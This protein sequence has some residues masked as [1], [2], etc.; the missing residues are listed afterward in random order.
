MYSLWS[1]ACI[2]ADGWPHIQSNVYRPPHNDKKM[3]CKCNDKNDKNVMIY[4]K[5]RRRRRINEHVNVHF[6]HSQVGCLTVNVSRFSHSSEKYL[7]YAV[8]NACANSY[9]Y[10]MWPSAVLSTTLNKVSS[11]SSG[12]GNSMVCNR[13][14]SKF[15][16]EI[17][18]KNGPYLFKQIP[19]KS[20]KNLIKPVGSISFV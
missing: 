7:I 1:P 10:L 14:K 6:T 17:Y 2:H 13:H 16:R 19:L 18:K 4:H 9:R 5:Y 8:Y 20:L 11:W 3:L 12:N 15:Q